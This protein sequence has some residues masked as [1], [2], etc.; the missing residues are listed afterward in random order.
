M[1]LGS[2]A[3][4]TS[5]VLSLLSSAI[6]P[7]L[8]VLLRRSE[9]GPH[10]PDDASD[11]ATK[12]YLLAFSQAF[13]AVLMFSAVLATSTLQGIAIV[14]TSGITWAIGQWVPFAIMSAQVDRK[15]VTK[16]ELDGYCTDR[17]GA[18]L[19]LYNTAISGPQ[20]L[21]S[22][23]CMIVYAIAGAAGSSVPTAWVLA[24]SGCTA[25]GS[26]MV[27]YDASQLWYDLNRK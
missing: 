13:T 20:I 6:I 26:S 22:V 25:L 8:V 7:A 9:S 27:A 12:F 14:A 17:T 1:R 23:L 24:S 19:G 2:L 18:T 16:I 15:Q 21:S 11:I 10:H 3:S 5:S 4:L